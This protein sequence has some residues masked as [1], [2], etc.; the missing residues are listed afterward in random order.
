MGCKPLRVALPNVLHRLVQNLLGQQLPEQ[1]VSYAAKWAFA[2][3]PLTQLLL[4]PAASPATV[5]P[6]PGT[7]QQCLHARV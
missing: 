2:G 5:A 7:I 4:Q 1:A 3:L 6:E